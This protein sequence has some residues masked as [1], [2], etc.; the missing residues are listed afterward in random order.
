MGGAPPLM[1]LIL[2]CYSLLLIGRSYAE[3][4]PAPGP[5]QDTGVSRVSFPPLSIYERSYI[6]E[7]EDVDPV[8]L[9]NPSRA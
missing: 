5:V 2:V 7:T 9:L 1:T 4:T 8:H 6:S 3:E